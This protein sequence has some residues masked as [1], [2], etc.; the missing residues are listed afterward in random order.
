[1]DP[2]DRLVPVNVHMP[3]DDGDRLGQDVVADSDEVHE[4]HRVVPHDAEDALVIVHGF[5]GCKRDNYTSGR[6]SVDGAFYLREGEDVLGV[7]DELEGGRQRRVVDDVEQPVCVVSERNLAKVHGFVR[8]VHVETVGATDA[9]KLQ[10]VATDGFNLVGGAGDE[11]HYLRNELGSYAEGSVW[12]NHA[13]KQAQA[14]RI[15]LAV[16]ICLLDGK[17]GWNERLVSEH[18]VFLG[19]LA[20]QEALEVNLLLADGEEGILSNGAHFDDPD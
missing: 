3:L 18:D 19:D 12:R 15:V 13:L 11:P 1:M 5:L 2:H 7:V 17:F 14:E 6:V 4:E 16:V 10:L 20:Y 9:G 8:E